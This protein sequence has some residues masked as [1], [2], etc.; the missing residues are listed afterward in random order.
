[1]NEPNPLPAD[2]NQETRDLGFGSVLSRE[3]RLR[4]LNRDGTF[5]VYRKRKST[6]RSMFTYHGLLSMSAP[7]FVA[8]VTVTYVVLNV[9]FAVAFMLCGPKALQP[10]TEHRFWQAFFFSVHTFAT[11]GYGNIWPVGMAANFVVTLESIVG[12]LSFALATGLIY[13]RFA[14]PTA[15]IIYSENA[16]VA[17]YR[18]TTAFEFRIINGRRNQLINLEAVVILTRFEDKQ[19]IKERQ[20]HYLAL[21]RTNVTF[22]PLAWTIVHP[23]NES[24]PLFGWTQEMLLKAR[25]EFLILL[26]GTDEVF[27]QIVHSR[28]S[29]AADEVL[30]GFRFAKLFQEGD[31]VTT[32]DMRKFHMIERAEISTAQQALN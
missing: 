6:W 31:G 30:W 1:M 16:I 17:P 25:A 21:E 29:Y 14:R 22:F 15:H 19:G 23:I 28:S 26:A 9:I 27:A 13:A 32:I 5:N 7:A 4:L 24:S 12:L 20:Y 10:V 2:I 18:G 3:Q 11:I 8:G